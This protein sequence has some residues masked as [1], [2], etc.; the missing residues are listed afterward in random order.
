MGFSM[1]LTFQMQ[2]NCFPETEHS[3][4]RAQISGA[5]NSPCLVTIVSEQVEHVDNGVV[6]PIGRPVSW[7]PSIFIL[8]FDVNIA[9]LQ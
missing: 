9:P 3:R 5:E 8:S 1:K 4:A 7:R 6:T 2:N